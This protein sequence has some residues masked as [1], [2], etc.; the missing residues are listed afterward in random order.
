MMVNPYYNIYQAE[1]GKTAAE[2]H[3]ADAQAGQFAA[4]LV[5]LGSAIVGPV[6]AVR[7]SL[8]RSR[9]A[10]YPAAS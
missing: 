1:R 4:E 9:P 10:A 6:R 5:Q 8:R 3:A 7:R 2:V